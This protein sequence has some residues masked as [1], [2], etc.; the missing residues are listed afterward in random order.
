MLRETGIKVGQFDTTDHDPA[1]KE[2]H[3]GNR[4]RPTAMRGA[5]EA[6]AYNQWLASEIQAS[7]EDPGPNIPHDAVMADMTADLN[8]LAP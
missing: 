6:A 1:D 2:P 8:A 3:A 4:G 5:H 7:I